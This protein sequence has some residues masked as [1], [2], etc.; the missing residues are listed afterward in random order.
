LLSLAL[1][2]KIWSDLEMVPWVAKKNVYCAEFGWI[3][4]R[5]QLGPLDLWCDLDLEFLYWYFCLDDLS[6]GDRR[7]LKSSITTVLEFI[8]VLRSFR[9]C[10]MEF[11]T[12][13]LGAYRL[14]IIS[15]WCIS[16]LISMES[17]SLSHLI[18][19]GLN[20]TLSKISFVTPACF[21]GPLAW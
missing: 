17:P 16:P 4:C 1:C 6:I 15:F 12:L 18:N 11:G 3:F 20:S 14:I 5:H 21:H 8:Y 19:V 13:M 2:P 9:V 7:V 10:L